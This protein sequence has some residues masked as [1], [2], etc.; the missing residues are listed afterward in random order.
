M[1]TVK[2]LARNKKIL[3]LIILVVVGTGFGIW[4]N[5][6]TEQP[7]QVGEVNYNPPTKAEV[8]ETEEFKKNLGSNDSGKSGSA[9][10]TVVITSLSKSEARGYVTGVFEDGGTCTLTLVKGS[11]QITSTSVAVSDVNKTTCPAISI[12]QSQL[13][14]G[15][16]TATLSYKSATTSG[17]SAPQELSVP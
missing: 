1:A 6:K 16:W 11:A 13:K 8:K 10:N 5:T 17:S 4:R 12:D 2:T 7:L 3:I 15:V 9:S 14:N